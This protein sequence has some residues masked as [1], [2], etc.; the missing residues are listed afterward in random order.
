MG[1]KINIISDGIQWYPISTHLD[2]V[3]EYAQIIFFAV[4]DFKEVE[5][6]AREHAVETL[7]QKVQA[8][9]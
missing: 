2:S 7:K 8:Y 3:L 9:L 6:A 4:R 1:W 5:S